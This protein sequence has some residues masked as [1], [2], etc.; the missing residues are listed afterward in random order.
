MRKK[1]EDRD[2]G[3]VRGSGV[4]GVSEVGGNR[5]TRTERAQLSAEMGGNKRRTTANELPGG[6]A[7]AQGFC[8]RSLFPLES[9]GLIILGE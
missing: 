3:N 6:E 5:T 1:T 8:P 4:N 2:A 9:A 7:G